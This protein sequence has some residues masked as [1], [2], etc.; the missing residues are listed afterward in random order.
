VTAP[1]ARLVGAGTLLALA[2]CS[3]SRQGVGLALGGAI[4]ASI[5]AAVSGC[6]R[7]TQPPPAGGRRLTT[8]GGAAVG[9]AIGAAAGFLLGSLLRQQEE[10]RLYAARRVLALI[11]LGTPEAMAATAQDLAR[12]LGLTVI[13]IAPLPSSG[14]GLV[15]YGVIRGSV[16]SLVEALRRRL[17]PRL[18]LV[19]PDWVYTLES[20]ADQQPPTVPYG[21]RLIRADRVRGAASGRGVVVAIVDAGV[22]ATHEGLRHALADTVDLTGQG[23]TPDVHGTLVAGIIAA[24]PAERVP[25]EGISPD[26]RL[27]AVKACVPVQADRAPARCLSSAL[28]LGVDHAATRDARVI[29][30]SVGGPRPDDLLGRLIGASVAQGRLVV[31]AAG[32]GG[33]RAKPSYPGAL[34]EVIAVTAVDAAEQLYRSATQG[35]YVDLAAPGVDIVTLAPGQGV[36]V[37]SGTSMAAAFVTATLALLLEPAAASSSRTLRQALEATARDLGPAGR[38]PRF[39]LGLIDACRAIE[40]VT[41]PVPACR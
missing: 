17:D 6:P 24:R 38:D 25:V 39:G 37:S 34:D 18:R 23:F 31:A 9:G 3:I 15:V 8:A 30:L 33:R 27:V 35:S 26:V 14:D 36:A 21:A 40:R 16:M 5:G 20:C 19:Q 32:N 13:R 22:D 12:G 2:G 4:G 11:P 41:A 1:L 28:A 7:A 10:G 29:N